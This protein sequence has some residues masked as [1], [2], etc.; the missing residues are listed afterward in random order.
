MLGEGEE[1][2]ARG[3][4]QRSAILY[5]CMFL[6]CAVLNSFASNSETATLECV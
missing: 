6:C 3:D 1:S 5:L 2:L 4:L